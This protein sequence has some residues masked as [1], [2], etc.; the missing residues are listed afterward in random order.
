MVNKATLF[1]GI[2]FAASFMLHAFG[3]FGLDF[4]PETSAVKKAPSINVTL[5]KSR[6]EEAPHEADFLAIHDNIGS[7]EADEKRELSSPFE[8]QFQDDQQHQ[9]ENSKEQQ[10]KEQEVIPRI[11]TT[12]GDAPDT[13]EKKHEEKIKEI[14]D[15][16]TDNINPSDISSKIATLNAQFRTQINEIANKPKPRHINSMMTQSAVETAYLALFRQ[17]VEQIATRNFP[18][19]ALSKNQFGNVTLKVVINSNGTLKSVRVMNAAP[20]DVLNKAAERSVYEAAPFSPIPKPVIE[21][22]Y[23]QLAIYATWVYGRQKVSTEL[24]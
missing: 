22:G 24:L 17:K 19:D 12:I 6:T 7:G 20:Y 11:I 10:Q 5:S 2:C 18:T 9:I 15:N 23:Q 16:P 8:N 13:M 14:Q 21:A 4:T 3:V 1:F